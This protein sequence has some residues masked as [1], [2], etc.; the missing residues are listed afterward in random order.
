M[1]TIAIAPGVPD[2]YADGTY[3]RPFRASTGE[4]FDAIFKAHRGPTRFILKAGEYFTKGSWNFP[5]HDYSM[6]AD[7]CEL[8]GEHGKEATV[9]YL[10]ENP[11]IEVDGEPA[12]N[13]ETLIAGRK[14]SSQKCHIKGITLRCDNGSGLPTSG[15]HTYSSGTVITDVDIFGVTGKWGAA[16]GFGILV[17]NSHE[18]DGPDGGHVVFRSTVY[19][20]GPDNYCTGIYVGAVTR[21]G[22]LIQPSSISDCLVVANQQDKRAHAAY[23]VNEYVRLTNCDMVGFE[24]F[25]FCDTGNVGDIEITGCRGDFGYCAIDF[26]APAGP[27]NPIAYRR[28]I[29]VSNCTFT[30]NHPTNDHAIALLAQDNTANRD[31]VNIEDI[32]V[33]GCRFSSALPAGAFYVVSIMAQHTARVWVRGSRFPA[34]SQTRNGVYPPTPQSQV[35]IDDVPDAPTGQGRS[36]GQPDKLPV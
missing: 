18:P 10:D 4:E 6:L 34:G 27:N 13:I 8:L 35:D 15:I 20:D 19:I 36:T 30:N 32:D 12:Q 26:P 11:V 23:A 21:P 2:P 24:R 17:N 33:D 7:N 16:E 25:C 28:R 31:L 3:D 22:V 14:G 9:I 1:K 29:R 5:E